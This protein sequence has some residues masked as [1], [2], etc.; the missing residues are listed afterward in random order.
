MDLILIFK[1][2]QRCERKGEVLDAHEWI[3]D[4]GQHQSWLSS[5]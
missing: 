2:K 3:Y 4:C 1:S 5:F